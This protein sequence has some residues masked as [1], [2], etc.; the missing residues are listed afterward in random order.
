MK[1]SSV[2]DVAQDVGIAV[3]LPGDKKEPVAMSAFALSTRWTIDD[4]SD[5][6]LDQMKSSSLVDVAQDVGTD[7]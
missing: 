2:V 7:V 4:S 5:N 3:G 1:Y 6:E